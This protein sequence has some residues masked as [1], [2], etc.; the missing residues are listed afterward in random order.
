MQIVHLL[1]DSLYSK[2][3]L[4]VLAI[5]TE[6]IKHFVL[7]PE[8]PKYIDISSPLFGSLD[9]A[10]FSRKNRIQR[11]SCLKEYVEKTDKLVAHYLDDNVLL[12]LLCYPSLAN[13]VCW[14]L[15]GGDLYYR[16]IRPHDIKSWLREKARER[17]IPQIP[18]VGMLVDGDYELLKKWYGF[19]GKRHELFYPLPSPLGTYSVDN[20]MEVEREIKIL[21]GNSADPSN[22]HK[23]IFEVLASKKLS[24][25]NIKII[26][27]LSYG[28]RNY[29]SQI[30]NYGRSLLGERFS[31]LFDFMSCDKYVAFMGNMNIV[32]MNHRR[33]Q[34]LGNI[35]LA[36]SLGKKVYVRSDTTSYAF[37]KS[38]NIEVYDTLRIKF[39]SVEDLLTCDA[40]EAKDISSKIK[41]YFSDENGIR[42]WK[43]FFEDI[44][45]S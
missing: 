41:S 21:V 3:F 43:K 5:N 22:N 9:I 29:A 24:E 7:L 19:R 18:Q 38:R 39:Q 45:N 10:C 27:P 40:S 12:L 6:A 32:I 17:V 15:W 20:N 13:K 34:G 26:C 42:L 35:L 28:D 33:Q 37:F 11:I 30:A 36:L 23:E 1:P 25:W 4:E 44:L 8:N 2:K 14:V 31:P 16:V